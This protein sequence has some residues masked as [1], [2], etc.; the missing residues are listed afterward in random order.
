MTGHV[1]LGLLLSSR[2]TT[3][4][5]DALRVGLP[6]PG[7]R[8]LIYTDWGAVRVSF[9]SAGPRGPAATQ[10][11]GWKGV[12]GQPVLRDRLCLATRGFSGTTH[13]CKEVPV[14]EKHAQDSQVR[15]LDSVLGSLCI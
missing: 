2:R 14:L 1:W 7:A 13:S 11:G 6:K 12:C 4:G 5:T 3:L 8:A 10:V 9:L 15:A